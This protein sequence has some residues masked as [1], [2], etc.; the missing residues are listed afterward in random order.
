MFRSPSCSSARR[1]P[2]GPGGGLRRPGVEELLH[3]APALAAR[4]ALPHGEL[5]VLEADGARRGPAGAAAHPV[6]VLDGEVALERPGAVAVVDEG[7][8][9]VSVARDPV[10]GVTVGEVKVPDGVGALGVGGGA[11]PLQL[12]HA[13]HVHRLPLVSG[14]DAE[15]PEVSGHAV[16]DAIVEFR[17][18]PPGVVLGAGVEDAADL[19]VGV[20]EVEAS[21]VGGERDV[22]LGEPLEDAVAPPQ[23]GVAEV[24]QG[25]AGVGQL[26]RDLTH[27]PEDLL[28][29]AAVSCELAAA[30]ELL[31][32]LQRVR[33]VDEVRVLAGVLDNAL[34]VD[35]E[36]AGHIALLG[37]L[38]VAEPL[39]AIAQ[40]RVE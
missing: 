27:A 37:R 40:T 24:L 28:E 26:R 14:E 33:A 21:N 15:L 32:A 5:L 25:D 7:L 3:E 20:E 8:Q 9:V 22:V 17:D 2:R 10:A 30:P 19:G 11:L 39:E 34:E 6:V 4:E 29:Q 36:V 1:L 18:G 13:G 16:D 23:F 35:D 38:N 31:Q 12:V